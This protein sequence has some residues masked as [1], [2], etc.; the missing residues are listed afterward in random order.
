M[1]DAHVTSKSVVPAEGLLL[2]TQMTP[3]L[4]LTIVMYSIFMPREVVAAAEDRVAR[5][6]GAGIDLLTLMWPRLIIARDIV[7]RGLR[8]V[9]C[10]CRRGCGGYGGR[11]GRGAVGFASVLL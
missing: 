10:A 9:G 11:D 6:A 1:H 2:G 4:L 3:N 8:V 7:R 5:L